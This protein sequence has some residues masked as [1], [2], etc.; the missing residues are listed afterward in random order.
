[1]IPSYDGLKKRIYLVEKQQSGLDTSYHDIE[2]P[3]SPLLGHSDSD[4][5]F[6]QYL[7]RE[8]RKITIFYE[9]QAA[10]LLEDTR[11][12]ETQVADQEEA[13]MRNY[14]EFDEEDEDEEDED[15]ERDGEDETVPQPGETSKPRK[16]GVVTSCWYSRSPL[17]GTVGRE[18]ATELNPP[19][20]EF[21]FKRRRRRP[22]C[23]YLL[24]SPRGLL[25]ARQIT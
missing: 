21:I 9:S 13:E 14:P 25:P 7:D 4:Q 19:K 2:S 18:K 3:R 12:L 15:G 8:L 11:D 5:T 20:T 10:E 1:M 17:T 23:R 16:K 6:S 22:R 24:P